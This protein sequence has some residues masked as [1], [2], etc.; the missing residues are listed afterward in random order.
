MKKKQKKKEKEQRKM[1]AEARGEVCFH[2]CR[3]TLAL[4]GNC[5]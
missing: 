5:E 1:E 4:T 2:G 3:C